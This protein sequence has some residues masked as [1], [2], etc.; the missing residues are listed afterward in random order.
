MYPR[1][2]RAPPK[3]QIT[4][5][6]PPPIFNIPDQILLS[7]ALKARQETGT[8]K[9]RTIPTTKPFALILEKKTPDSDKVASY[10]ARKTAAQAYSD[11]FRLRLYKEDVEADTTTHTQ[12]MSIN[13]KIAS[14]QLFTP[15]MTNPRHFCTT[16]ERQLLLKS[17]AEFWKSYRDSFAWYPLSHNF[18]ACSNDPEML[19]NVRPLNPSTSLH[20]KL[21]P[22]E[23]INPSF[24][25]SKHFQPLYTF[26]RFKTTQRLLQIEPITEISQSIVTNHKISLINELLM[27]G[28]NDLLEISTFFALHY[29]AVKF[30]L[31]P[32]DEETQAFFATYSRFLTSNILFFL[33]ASQD[34]PLL[35]D[36]DPLIL[37]TI[38]EERTA[39]EQYVE[40]RSPFSF[41][42]PGHIR[43]QIFY[44]LIRSP[45]GRGTMCKMMNVLT[46]QSR[47]LSLRL[48]A[49]VFK[50]IA[51][52]FFPFG[53]ETVSPTPAQPPRRTMIR[54]SKA[55]QSTRRI[56]TFDSNDDLSASSAFL[57]T[58]ILAL[59]KQ[60]D[61]DE[62]IA[63][64]EFA[65]AALKR[66]MPRDLKEEL[67]ASVPLQTAKP[68]NDQIADFPESFPSEEQIIS[69]LTPIESQFEF[70]LLIKQPLSVLLFIA[71]TI[72]THLTK[73]KDSSTICAPIISSLLDL[74]FSI[75]GSVTV[76]EGHSE[77]IRQGTSP[78]IRSLYRIMLSERW[79]HSLVAKDPSPSPI[80][81][82]SKQT[83]IPKHVTLLP[84][85]KL[86]FGFVR[87]LLWLVTS[88]AFENETDTSKWID[89]IQSGLKDHPII[90]D[91]LPV[92]LKQHQFSEGE[93]HIFFPTEADNEIIFE[94][95]SATDSPPLTSSPPLSSS[96]PIQ[97][98]YSE[99]QTATF[100]SGSDLS[101]FKSDG[102]VQMGMEMDALLYELDQT[103]INQLFGVSMPDP[104]PETESCDGPPGLDSADLSTEPSILPEPQ[105]A[106]QQQPPKSGTGTLKSLFSTVLAKKQ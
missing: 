35:P 4:P 13:R 32:L 31:E 51:Y 7:L 105:L 33:T 75:D 48:I 27:D 72:N 98:G 101:G 56:N 47:A 95:S 81:T 70:S 59:L 8:Q 78:F 68:K 38:L 1:D 55:T 2:P 103:G 49:N 74:F 83:M 46:Y 43:D 66:E 29:D 97:L 54:S 92:Y 22:S 39:K 71:D 11:A 84:S 28:Y 25:V 67:A 57:C 61:P 85:E 17:N 53:Y 9:N 102:T 52:S 44:R 89:L 73:R 91:I 50:T 21:L 45:K 90:I 26:S 34:I 23:L 94:A 86:F 36:S 3:L 106:S 58:A 79:Q 87:R 76:G 6:E 93:L 12:S 62:I 37:S 5:P 40:D 19:K 14:K 30:Q 65:V 24:S 69:R 16:T 63:L 41:I 18:V 100:F 42:I 64:F 88:E 10:D 99:N 96:P 60:H 80:R 77:Q 104:S 15:I 82:T 20:L